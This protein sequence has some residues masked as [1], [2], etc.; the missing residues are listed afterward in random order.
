MSVSSRKKKRKELDESQAP[1]AH[2]GFTIFSLNIFYPI[3]CLPCSRSITYKIHLFWF[4]SCFLALILIFC[5]WLKRKISF[6]LVFHFDFPA[7]L[8]KIYSVWFLKWRFWFS[9]WAKY[10]PYPREVGKIPS[11]IVSNTQ[12]Q[13]TQTYITAEKDREGALSEKA[14]STTFRT[15]AAHRLLS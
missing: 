12:G 9:K 8:S 11:A 15:V 4:L 14:A 7:N 13:D 5:P 10:G 6:A 1:M 3:W 2:K